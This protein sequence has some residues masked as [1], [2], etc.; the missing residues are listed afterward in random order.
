MSV[1]DALTDAAI[2]A[3]VAAAVAIIERMLSPSKRAAAFDGAAARL[4]FR[5]RAQARQ[6][7][8]AK[9]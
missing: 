8:R 2:R 1:A 7:A 3:A 6:D 4:L 9:R 5:A